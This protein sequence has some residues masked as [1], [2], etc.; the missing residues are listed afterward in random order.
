MT[1]SNNVPGKGEIAMPF[2]CLD[3]VPLPQENALD[4]KAM[5]TMLSSLREQSILENGEFVTDSHAYV[6]ST[7]CMRYGTQVYVDT[8]L[9]KE[10]LEVLPGDMLNLHIEDHTRITTIAPGRTIVLR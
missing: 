2:N 10:F 9:E 7:E 8:A 6:L 4:K 3:I 1:S 5:H